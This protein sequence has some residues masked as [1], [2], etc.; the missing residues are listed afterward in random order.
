M[1]ITSASFIKGVTKTSDPI[2]SD[3]LSQIGFVGR[4][5]VGKSSIIN[6]LLNR[7]NLVKVGKKPGKTTEINFFKVNELFYLVDLPGYGYAKVTIAI[8]NKI[9]EMIYSYVS[10]KFF[11]PLCVVLVLDVKAGLTDLDKEM[12]DIL[13]EQNQRYVV[14]VNKVDKLNQKE[15]AEKVKQIE[16]EALTSDVFTYSTLTRKGTFTKFFETITQKL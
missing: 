14:L 9:R 13:R 16:R 1:T 10:D 4:S 12:I 3:G 7:K 5:N 11:T 6:S 2:F 15:V 8:K